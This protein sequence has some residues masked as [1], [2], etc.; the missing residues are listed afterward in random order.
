MGSSSE[1]NEK[2]ADKNF[3]SDKL[4]QPRPI[5]RILP[6]GV[7]KGAK[8]FTPPVS[9]KLWRQERWGPAPS[10][11]W[12]RPKRTLTATSSSSRAAHAYARM[13]CRG[14]GARFD[15]VSDAKSA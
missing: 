7:S 15:S 9:A 13:S 6:T 8:M 2:S 4:E 14:S 3:D 1:F 5:T 11:T 10:S 12:R